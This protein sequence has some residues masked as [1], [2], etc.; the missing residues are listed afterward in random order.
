[1]GGDGTL[2]GERMRERAEPEGG[3][4]RDSRWKFL[5]VVTV[6]STALLIMCLSSLSVIFGKFLS[7]TYGNTCMKLYI[8]LSAAYRTYTMKMSI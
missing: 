2:S 5:F 3:Q 1:M 8:K 7:A 4:D 6:F